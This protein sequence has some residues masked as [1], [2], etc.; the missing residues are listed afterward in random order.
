MKLIDEDRGITYRIVIGVTATIV[1]WAIIHDQIIAQIAPEHFTEYHE[2]VGNIKNPYVLAFLWAIAATLGLGLIM[3]IVYAF[4]GRRGDRP[5]VSVRFIL[6]GTIIMVVLIEL[7]SS[8]TGWWVFRTGETL[9]PDSWYPVDELGILVTQTM[10]ISAYLTSA[11]LSTTFGF[12]VAWK[13][14]PKKY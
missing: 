14:I 5:K 2:P 13:R 3:G 9:Y 6:V 7:V 11:V 8:G 4:L 12:L 10:Q 1:S